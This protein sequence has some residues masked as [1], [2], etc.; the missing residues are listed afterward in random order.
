MSF[1]SILVPYRQTGYFSQLVNDY[2]D[3]NEK[4]RPFYRYSPL[5]PD[6]E[7]AFRSRENFDTDRELLVSELTKQYQGLQTAD[8]VTA[9]IQSLASP[10]TFTVCTAH[11]PNIFTGYLYFIYK[12]IQTV[13]LAEFLENK[14]PGRHVVPV[15]YMGSEDSDLEELNRINLE[16][17][18]FIWNPG[19]TGAVGR[20]TTSGLDLLITEIR[21]TI[22]YGDHAL[23]LIHL[24]EEAYQG[25]P[26]IQRATLQF[27]NALFGRFG[28][29]VVIADTPGFKRRIL[30]LIREELWH[31]PSYEI[32]RSTLQK[33][34]VHYKPQANPREINL[35]YLQGQTR[36]RIVREK[37][38]WQVLNTGI[39]FSE[40]QL[41]TEVSEHPERFSPNVIL[42]GILQETILPNLAF[43]GGGG[44]LSYWLELKD[45]Y[46]HFK[47]PYP[48]LILRNS[49]L[50]IDRQ[51]QERLKKLELSSLEL[52][53]PLEQL[54]TAYTKRHA[55][56]SLELDEEKSELGEL[57]EHLLE[58]ALALDPTLVEAVK[59]SRA[60]TM[61][62]MDHIALKFL[63]AQKKKMALQTGQIRSVREKLFPGNSLQERTENIIPFYAQYGALFL[64]TLYRLL[65]PLAN[66]FTL[67]QED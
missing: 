59:A 34:S 3:G 23:E 60:K 49:V 39:R 50:W 4:L 8:R 62:T 45:L 43:V 1:S 41:E 38:Y 6:F 30:P 27:V 26:D 14:Y 35:F 40:A 46:D 54:I 66:Q 28:L 36:E 10:D 2:L 37:D 7:E 48:V 42:R 67:I 52:F 65:D 31:S 11:Q 51:N 15:Y 24:L 21:Q 5:N 53:S 9:H 25:Q 32:V 64:D 18:A 17:K 63:R 56:T 47:T 44:E 13:K 19:Q 61:Q 12:L 58:R 20:M 29:V 57:F 22:G 16:G 33:L 55:E